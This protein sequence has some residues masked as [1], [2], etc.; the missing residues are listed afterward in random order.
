MKQNQALTENEINL[1]QIKIDNL[2]LKNGIVYPDE[3]EDLTQHVSEKSK[4]AL[5]KQILSTGY[6]EIDEDGIL[7]YIPKEYKFSYDSKDILRDILKPDYVN[8]TK[9]YMQIG[10]T[11]YKGII[12]TRFP[13]NPK[14][15]WL[16]KLASEKNNI[17]YALF[18]SESNLAE[19][20]LHLR[21]ELRKVENELYSYT[22]KGRVNPELE[23]KRQELEEILTSIGREFQEFNVV[24]FVL[25]KGQTVEDIN[26]LRS[27]VISALRGEDIIAE[28]AKYLH[29]FVLKSV[30][31]NGSNKLKRTELLVPDDSLS[32]SFPFLHPFQDISEDDEI[33]LGFNESELIVTGN[34][35][36]LDSYSGAYLGVTGSGKSLTLKYELIQQMTVAGARIIVIDPA[37]AKIKDV[38]Y[39]PEYYRMCQLVGGKY[40]SFSTDSKNI[41][42]MMAAFEDEKFEDEMRRIYSIVRVFFEDENKIVPEPQKPLI[43]I[44]VVEAFK[45]KG[46]TRHTKDFWKKKQPKLEDLLWALKRGLHSADTEATK[47]SY[48]A[49]I[50]RLEPCVGNG[51]RSYLNTD[52]KEENINN[53]FTVF[54][55]KDTPVDDTRILIMRLLSFIKKVMQQWSRTIIVLEE[56][57]LWL[58]DPYLSDF[59]ATLEVT[60]RKANTGLRLVFQDLGQLENCEEGLTLLGNLSFTY[61]FKTKPNL[62]PLTKK[63]FGLNEAETKVLETS[64]AGDFIILIWDTQHYKMKINVDPETYKII[65]TNPKELKKIEEEER[66]SKAEITT[67]KLLEQD[68]GYLPTSIETGL[69]DLANMIRNKPKLKRLLKHYPDRYKK[70][71]AAYTRTKK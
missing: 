69:I 20:K 6:V 54:E 41:P 55:F 17:D 29:E 39:R 28:E 23:R 40:I 62:I 47:M 67:R 66:S 51:L 21:R 1:I 46:I 42:N 65:T 58:K 43:Q 24:L 71:L 36:N 34:V 35:W 15:D 26:N 30:I 13:S 2:L 22:K 4:E 19:L 12:C 61:L 7:K 50:K 63:S 68:L 5:K 53:Q 16:S 59:I 9:D 3:F 31:P 49:L 11:F 52:A 33:I 64:S 18:R 70:L 60:A 10:R 37:A 45:R 56:A 44:A 25:V 14:T 32:R 48:E 57:H 38:N 8:A 27:Y